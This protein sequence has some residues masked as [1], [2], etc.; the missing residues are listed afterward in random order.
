MCLI[1]ISLDKI[2]P[3]ILETEVPELEDALYIVCVWV[4]L[5]CVRYTRYFEQKHKTRH[6]PMKVNV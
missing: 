6:M 2:A 1:A 4:T 5:V 3:F